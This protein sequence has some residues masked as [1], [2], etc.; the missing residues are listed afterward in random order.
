MTMGL[1]SIKE[2]Q[3]RLEQPSPSLATH[4]MLLNPASPRSGEIGAV[5]MGMSKIISERVVGNLDFTGV[6]NTSAGAIVVEES[7]VYSPEPQEVLQQSLVND[8]STQRWG[9]SPQ[10]HHSMSNRDLLTIPQHY[11]D[12]YDGD[13]GLL[14]VASGDTLLRLQQKPQLSAPN[15]ISQWKTVQDPASPVKIPTNMPRTP[16]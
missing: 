15:D 8:E 4:D 3:T 12:R 13:V 10:Q 14:A 2:A 9:P 16:F 7:D 1:E 5:P 6:R 11:I